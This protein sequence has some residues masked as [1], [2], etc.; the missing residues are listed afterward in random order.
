MYEHFRD[1][2]RFVS[3]AS[4]SNRVVAIAPFNI[5]VSASPAASRHYNHCVE[6]AMAHGLP[7]WPTR[8][9]I[10]AG[11]ACEHLVVNRL[12]SHPNELAHPLLAA[13]I[14]GRVHGA[15]RM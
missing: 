7:I 9:E 15:W 10:Y 13:G 2:A 3:L 11:H 6:V 12:D 5:G 1:L 4:T 14:A 8:Q